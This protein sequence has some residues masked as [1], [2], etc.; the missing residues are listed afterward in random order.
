M[1][2]PRGSQWRKWDLHVHTPESFFHRYEGGADVWNKYLADIES[3][4]SEIKVIGV[5]DYIFLDGYKR[6]VQEKKAGRLQNIE[7]LLPVIELRLDKFGGSQGHLSKV[8]FHV[9][10]SDHV[11]AAIIQEQ[12]LAGLWNEYQLTPTYEGI[13]KKWK[14]HPTL[15]SIEE[16]GKLIIDSV[17]AEKRR[18]FGSPLKEGF[19]NITFSLDAIK[20]AIDKH[21]FEGKHL[22][23]VGK[24]E[25]A[26]VK[27]N[28]NSIA[29]KKNVINVVDL[30]FTAASGPDEYA[31]SRSALRTQEVN[32]KLLDCSDAHSF[33]TSTEKDRLGN[34]F[35][36]I[37]A[38][39]TFS[40]LKLAVL[41]F[42]DRVFI[43]DEPHKIKL[44]RQ[45]RTQFI[46][47]V[48][49]KNAGPPFDEVWFNG[50]VPL[51]HDL[52]AIV[53][54]K[55]NGKSA[56][57]D[58]I[59]LLGKSHQWS[60][61]SFLNEDRFRDPRQNKAR[62]F[63]AALR[64]ESGTG[65]FVNLAENSGTEDIELVKYIPQHFL[66]SICN[67]KD[68]SSEGDFDEEL[69]KIIFSHVPAAD[70]LGHD[71]LDELIAYKVGETQ[72]LIT[73]LRHELEITNGQIAH[74]EDTL[75]G[76]YKRQLENGIAT[77]LEEL[78]ANE[79]IKPVEVTTP[80]TSS[81]IKAITDKN[82]VRQELVGKIDEYTRHQGTDAKMVSNLDR[83]LARIA[84]FRRSFDS[85]KMEISQELV[86]FDIPVDTL[87]RLVIDTSSLERKRDEFISSRAQVDRLL[88]PTNR[89]GPKYALNALDAEIAALQ[90]T[91]DEPSRKF[92]A[93]ITE[94]NE[95][96]Q[97]QKAINGDEFTPGTLLYFKNQL[98]SLPDARK[99][100]GDLELSR[101]TKTAEIFER[102]SALC[103]TYR[104]LYRAVSNF[105]TT[106]EIAKDKLKLNFQVS[107]VES[108]FVERFFEYVSRGVIGSFSGSE[109]GANVLKNIIRKYDFNFYEQADRFIE[110]ILDHLHF[111]KREPEGQRSV[112]VISQLRRGHSITELYDYVFSLTYLQP[113][114]TLKL[115]D[116]HLSQL[117]PGEKGALLLIFYLLVDQGEMP[118]VIDQ[119]EENLDNQ[120]VYDLLVPCLKEAKHKRQV[121]IVTHNP[122]LAVVAD[123]EQIIHSFLDKSDKNRMVYTSGAIENPHIR[124]K[125]I[126]VL[127]GTQPAFDNRSTKYR[128]AALD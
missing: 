57:A 12:F 43:G 115:G 117:S 113:R 8:N 69:K 89:E 72:R 35:T 109:E 17:P 74:L 4:P 101:H 24:T 51:N 126:D 45:N 19:S 75:S 67:T 7:L 61:F 9:I 62:H 47:S 20:K 108:G 92:Q 48:V 71:S 97:K 66:E 90:E 98:D 112:G 70:R 49:F 25:W 65:K 64:W 127:E 119:P 110:D 14:A 122:N 87:V 29:D 42:E 123:A 79:S 3:L 60:S 41:E 59:G 34:C 27:W 96:E 102:I 91:L 85:F 36:W 124:Q 37:K 84:T 40:G 54:N 118:L 38:D 103:D 15:A 5:N 76:E 16:L 86:E 10:F 94:R 107:I 55:G 100:L 95:W 6:L 30:V 32:A 116:K 81:I 83:A 80:E 28:D 114:Y 46:D 52:V 99:K 31:K 125:V 39:S 11:D 105:I 13:T 82:D 26:D 120:T 111:D 73:D 2:D 68:G 93:Y 53:G 88:E 22:F 50:E 44:V 77:K 78:K 106:H 63:E 104:E 21:Y 56:L 121:I 33:S 1:N 128:F 18:D 58:T 23:A